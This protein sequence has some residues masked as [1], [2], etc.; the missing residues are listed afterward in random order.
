MRYGTGTSCSTESDPA[1]D[2]RTA[3]TRGAVPREAQRPSAG[4]VAGRSR[5]AGWFSGA[6]QSP[7]W[8]RRSFL[9]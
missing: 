4:S 9:L 7:L 6:G 3:A 1:P 5:P 2:P 8:P